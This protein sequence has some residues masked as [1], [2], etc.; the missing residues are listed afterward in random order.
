MQAVVGIRLKLAS[1]QYTYC[2]FSNSVNFL[3]Q[4]VMGIRLKL[5][6]EKSPGKAAFPG[7]VALFIDHKIRLALEGGRS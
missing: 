2:F 5:A 6:G 4:A 1:A 7:L 3:M